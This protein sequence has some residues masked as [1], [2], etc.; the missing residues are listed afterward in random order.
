MLNFG[1]GITV[2]K[3]VTVSTFLSIL[4]LENS[5]LGICNV[6]VLDPLS[7]L[8]THEVPILVSAEARDA[9]V[10]LLPVVPLV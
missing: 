10:P 3:K 7:I 9:L 6:Q 5:M 2:R 4:F 1:K 8:V